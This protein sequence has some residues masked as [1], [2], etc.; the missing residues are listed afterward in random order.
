M[1][2]LRPP[3]WADRFLQWYC[4]PDRLDEIQGDAYELFYRT[5]SQNKNKADLHFIW[6]VIRF[7]RWGNIRQPS[8]NHSNYNSLSMLQNYFKTGWRSVTKQKVFSCINIFGL[9]IGLMSFMLIASFVYDEISYDKYASQYKNIY[10]VGLQLSQNG[11]VDDYPHVDIAVADGMKNAFPDIIESTR[12][13]GPFTDYVKDADA[14]IKEE[15]LVMADSNFLN[16]FSIGLL[17]GNADNA[18]TEPNSIVISKSFAKKHFGDDPALGKMLMMRRTGLLKVTGIFSQIPE[19]SHFHAEAIISMTTS[20]MLTR[21]QTWSNVGFF[22]YLLLNEHTDPRK[23][24]SKFPSL[25]DKYVAPEVQEDMGISLADAKKSVTSWKFYLMPLSKIHLFSHTKYEFE[26]NGDIKNVYI[27]GTLAV[28]I[29]LLACINFM[30]L[31]TATSAKRAREIGIRKVMGSVKQQLMLQFLVESIILAFIALGISLI[32]TMVLLPYFNELTGKHFDVSFF[33]SWKVIVLLVALGLTVGILAGAYPAVFLSSFQTLRVLK[34][35]TSSGKSGNFRSVLV[36]FQFAI[37]TVL[38]IA[39][40]VAYQQLHHM[41]N[42]KMGYDKSQ[43]LV[44]ENVSALGSNVPVFQRQLEQDH[45]VEHVSHSTVPLGKAAAFEGSEVTAKGH[46]TSTIHS[47]FFMI[48]HNYLETLGLELVA[49]RNFSREFINDSLGVNVIINE[50]AMRDLGLDKN[51][52]LGSKIIRSAQRQYEVIGVVKDFHYTSAKDKIAPLIMVNRAVAPSLLV[53]VQSR[54]MHELIDGIGKL[55]TSLNTDVPYSFY[56]VDDRFNTLYKSEKI[57]EKI[58]TIF[59]LIAIIIASLGLYGLSAYSAEQRTK[60]IGIRKVLGSSVAQIVFLQSK[61]FLLLVI[62]AIAI[63]AP[64]SWWVMSQ[65]LQNFGYRINIDIWIIVYAALSAIG[66]ALITVSFQAIK[67][68]LLN[69][70]KCLR[71]ESNV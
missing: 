5:A 30:N 38:I 53:K 50:T 66:V 55:W 70:V 39:T 49:G 18:L 48:D 56:F 69:P 16:M 36:V 26:P 71:S 8:K 47:H 19:R 41:Q 67:A 15:S 4:R 46:L 42:L 51:N 44:V 35:N 21:R 24:E 34:A 20:P 45:R 65:W 62:I 54:E 58:F 23:L 17:E 14:S 29:L 25:V 68:A 57:T 40:L 22:S 9:A 11:G 28:F 2:N 7:F 59:M 3:K 31:S 63:A 13:R 32:F 12:L 64:I 33:L 6:N 43:L 37:S 52:V 61:Q 27:F 10:R 60:E 1:K